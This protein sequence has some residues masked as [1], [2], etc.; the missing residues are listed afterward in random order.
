MSVTKDRANVTPSEN[1][2]TA[3]KHHQAAALHHQDAAK[4]LEN[5]HEE[6]AALSS[7]KAQGHHNLASKAQKKNLK[8]EASKS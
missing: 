2:K 6:K 1:H 8:H 7:I 4:H 5:G 3:A